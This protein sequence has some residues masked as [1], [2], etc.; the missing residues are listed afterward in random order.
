M[1]IVLLPA[2]L[3]LKLSSTVRHTT[4]P[5]RTSRRLFCRL[6]F[7]RP[8]RK[9]V[10]PIRYYVYICSLCTPNVFSV[11]TGSSPEVDLHGLRSIPYM[12]FSRTGITDVTA[13]TMSHVLPLHPTPERLMPYF[14]P[15]KAG[16]QAE[17]L[18]S[19]YLLGCRGIVYHPNGGLTTLGNFVLE[20]AEGMREGLPVE[21]LVPEASPF[22]PPFIP[23][24]RRDSMGIVIASIPPTTHLDMQR[25]RHKIE[26]DHSKS[27]RQQPDP[28][29]S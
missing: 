16:H 13:L 10:S 18:D 8:S 9:K 5:S 14:T 26:L 24:R 3:D 12:V 19:Y 17:I 1:V 23:R 4:S 7:H 29:S 11:S 15:A 2:Q 22:Q 6:M 28:I 27:T 20:R 25:A 21:L